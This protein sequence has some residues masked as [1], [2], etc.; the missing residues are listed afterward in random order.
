MQDNPQVTVALK[1]GKLP[2]TTQQGK[3]AFLCIIDK[4]CANDVC[5]A[6]FVNCKIDDERNQTQVGFVNI[7]TRLFIIVQPHLIRPK[8][9]WTFWD[10]FRVDD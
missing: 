5:F 10:E 9:T 6:I 1:Y 7:F 3:T 8:N 2:Y 4:L